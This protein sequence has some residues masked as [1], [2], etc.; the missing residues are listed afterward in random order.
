MPQSLANLD[1]NLLLTLDALL[2]ERNVT[3]AAAR[4]GVSQ[5]AVSA[6]LARLRRHFGD[7]LLSRVGNR[8]ELTPLALQLR[9]HTATALASVQRV[10]DASPD[11]EPAEA[12]REF[13]FLMS[14][15]AA[16]VLG[17]TLAAAV[18]REAPGVRLR[19]PMHTPD[20]VDHAA[21]TLRVVD[22]IVLPHGFISD[23]PSVDLFDDDWVGLVATEHPEVGSSLTMDQL[24][25]LPWVL[26]YNRPTAFTPPSSTCG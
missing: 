24:A 19:L 2:E 7:E 8:Y 18:A 11:F 13:T 1:L 25:T 9:G 21:E 14:D 26:T 17:P 23:F 12:D 10:F 20:A 15:Y 4:V 3:R 22:G 5:P 6:A 16:A